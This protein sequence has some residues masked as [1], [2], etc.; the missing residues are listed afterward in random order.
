MLPEK[1]KKIIIGVITIIVSI[2]VVLLLWKLS[3]Y[4]KSKNTDND[5][6]RR[7]DDYSDIYKYV[8]VLKDEDNILNFYGINDEEVSLGV[9]T[10]YDIEDIKVYDKKLRM[11][12]DATN[13]L[14]YD[15][16]DNEYYFY[17]L[18][19]KYSN[20]YEVKINDKYVV[21]LSDDTLKY[22]EYNGEEV[23][24]NENVKI[25]SF[26]LIDDIIYYMFDGNLYSY[27]IK[28]LKE[29]RILRLTSDSVLLGINNAY[30]YVKSNEELIVYKLEGAIKYNIKDY[31]KDYEFVTI[32]FNGFILKQD[33]T[34]KEYSILTASTKDIISD[35]NYEVLK[36]IKLS[37]SEYFMKLNNEME[38]K[39]VIIDIDEGRIIKELDNDYLYMVK[40]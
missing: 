17:E 37:N 34:L 11:Y 27:D 16:K 20:K 1:K 14:R 33:N 8:G 22:W 39:Y 29:E 36:S 19:T 21:V 9:R 2:V 7:N 3:S 18:D 4:I 26:Y 40:L 15:K 12:A 13:E 31:I 6:K 10:F 25:D 23:I 5:T 35:F 30:A 32:S 24:I 28:A 38:E